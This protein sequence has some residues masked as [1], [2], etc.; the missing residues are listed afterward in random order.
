MK[1][2]VRT[3]LLFVFGISLA[4]VLLAAGVFLGHQADVERVFDELLPGGARQVVVGADRSFPLQE[5]VLDSLEEHFYREVD[6][7]EL[8]DDAVRGLLKGLEDDYT[9]YLDPEEY[10]K[11]K[12]HAGGSYSGVGM[13]VEL[14]GQLVT[15]VSTF[16]G[17]PAL[18][19]GIK[20]GDVIV[21]VD[22]ESTK[23]LGL[24]EVVRRIKGPEGSKVRLGIYDTSKADAV[25]LTELPDDLSHFPEGAIREHELVRKEIQVPVVEA[26]TTEVADK[27][28]VHLAFFGFSE[29]SSRRLREEVRAAVEEERAD[30]ILLDLRRNGG[31]LLHE[32]VDVASIFLEEGI[33]VTTEGLHS[34]KEV[35][36]AR[37]KAFVDIPL[38]VLIDEFSASASEIVAGA[39]QDSKRATIVGET[40]F[41]KGL[42]QQITPLSNGGALKVTTA[43]YLTPSGRDINKKGIEPQVAAVDDLS[44]PDVD[45]ALDRTLELIGAG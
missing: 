35:Y 36:R 14:K 20:P 23:G 45:E 42:V 37:G 16:K 26:K 13:S 25:V 28:V 7:E 27:K 44:T 8:E 18:E 41:G 3:A 12:E 39:V 5:E 43:V 22:G 2:F 29:G 10:A 31:G 11:F 15:V 24:E 6:P 38:Y 17:S 4:V 21:S 19:A 40:S 32:A 33:I 9:A 34:A 30:A 1:H